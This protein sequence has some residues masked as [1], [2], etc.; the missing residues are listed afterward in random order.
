MSRSDEYRHFAAVCLKLAQT[1]DDD[2]K[3]AKF[4]EMAQAW[5]FLA[6][7]EETSAGADSTRKTRE[8][9]H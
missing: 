4:L 8:I 1:A 6:E 2:T 3:R 9:D 7:K 5:F